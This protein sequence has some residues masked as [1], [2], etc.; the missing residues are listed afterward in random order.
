VIDGYVLNKKLFDTVIARHGGAERFDAIQIEYA[1]IIVQSILDMRTSTPAE[2]AKLNDVITELIPQLPPRVSPK[3]EGRQVNWGKM[4]LHAAADLYARVI[5]NPD[6]DI[7]DLMPPREENAPSGA[8]PAGQ[9]AAS[10]TPPPAPASPTPS[11]PSGKA[12]D[13]SARAR[14]PPP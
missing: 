9:A 8:R 5:G 13:V 3:R 10:P 1:A 14:C 11:V 12:T 4:T 7:E 2:R 6:A